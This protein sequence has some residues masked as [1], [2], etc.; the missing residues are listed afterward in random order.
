MSCNG[1]RQITA[2]EATIKTASIEVKVLTLNGKQ[3]TL[4]VFRQLKD[5]RLVN[6][7]TV[8]LVGQPWGWVNYHPDC[9]TEREHLHVVWQQG[10]W[11]R[12]A[13]VFRQPWLDDITEP[14]KHITLVDTLQDGY[15]HYLVART[16]A[17]WRPEQ[18]EIPLKPMPDGVK[19]PCYTARIQGRLLRIFINPD[20]ASLLRQIWINSDL[21]THIVQPAKAQLLEY[22][23]SR[24]PASPGPEQTIDELLLPAVQKLEMYEQRWEQLYTELEALDQLFIAV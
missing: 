5:E 24:W 1:K 3:M 12:R 2:Q 17:G 23:S 21:A 18:K 9:H 16:S 14:E 7:E 15:L 20:L 13:L 6:D 10:Q 11:L 8:E 4:S 19:W 22:L